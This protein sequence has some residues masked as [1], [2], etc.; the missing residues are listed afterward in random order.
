LHAILSPLH[1]VLDSA[2]AEVTSEVFVDTAPPPVAASTGPQDL[3]KNREEPAAAGGLTAGAFPVPE[4]WLS[5]DELSVRAEPLTDVQIQYPADLAQRGV[6]GRV[7]LVLH[8]D[9]RGVVR[10]TQVE[11]SHPEGLFD[12]AALSAWASVRFSPA[13]KDGLAVKSRKLLEV[14]FL[15]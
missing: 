10:K 3:I 5:A 8:I 12:D 15:P 1:G 4:R 9:E 6:F 13:L 7:R 11:E 14:S 2:H